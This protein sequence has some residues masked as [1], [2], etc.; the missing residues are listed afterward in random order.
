MKYILSN[1]LDAKQAMA[2]LRFLTTKGATIEL[3]EKRKDRTLSQNAYLHLILT[4]WGG[5]LGYTLEEIKQVAKG[6]RPDLFRYTH[7]A[8]GEV[9][10]RSTAD[11]NTKEMTDLID[12][13]RNKA[14]QQGYYIPE[15][16][17]TELI[18]SLER[19]A[20]RYSVFL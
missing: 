17:E 20:N 19:E 3:T 4:A 5:F 18:A 8:T 6:A 13:I 15:P 1:R 14:G 12:W 10:N 7:K 16:N 11:L 9:F 2:R